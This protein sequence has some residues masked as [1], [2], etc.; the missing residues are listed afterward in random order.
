MKENKFDIL[1]HEMLHDNVLIKALTSEDIR[2]LTKEFS[3]GKTK[4]IDP[5]QYEDKPEWGEVI[6]IGKGRVLESGELSPINVNVG[7]I[8]IY[9]KYSPYKTRVDGKDYLVVR[10]ED[11]LTKI[12]K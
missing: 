2:E 6:S 9:G 4:L 10:D 5:E 8:V 1:N 11:I 7:D 12:G 3:K